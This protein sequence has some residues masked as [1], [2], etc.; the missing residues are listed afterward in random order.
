METWYLPP[1][2]ELRVFKHLRADEG[3]V[4]HF[5]DALEAKTELIT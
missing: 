5:N 2:E 1:I 4:R 3:T